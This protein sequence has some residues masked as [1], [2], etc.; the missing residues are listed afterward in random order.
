MIQLTSRTLERSWDRLDLATRN[1]FVR[2]ISVGAER[3][4]RMIDN[5]LTLARLDVMKLDEVPLTDTREVV[6]AVVAKA[7]LHP[8]DKAKV[9]GV[10]RVVA[11]PR[12][13]VEAILAN[14]VDNA[15]HYGRSP[16]G[17]L[18]A[19]ICGSV[20]HGQVIID[21]SDAGLGIP[22]AERAKIF[23]PFYFAPGSRDINPMSTGVGL[24]IVRRAAERWGGSVTALAAEPSGTTMRI[25]LPSR[26]AG[27]GAR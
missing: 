11:V 3:A 16:D 19:R 18:R 2:Q 26:K 5:M 21:V 14:L 27:S 10:W 20:G 25:T 15:I 4:A 24:A 23:N 7:A 12:S 13:D 8:G 1:D 9:H 6:E 17:V 22:D